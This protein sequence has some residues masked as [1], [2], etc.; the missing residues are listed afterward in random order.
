MGLK[1]G[2]L[3]VRPSMRTKRLVRKLAEDSAFADTRAND[4][5]RSWR[6]SSRDLQEGL[7]VVATEV[8]ESPDSTDQDRRA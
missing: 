5:D 1:F 7:D 2:F 6:R 4:F 8:Q 3:P